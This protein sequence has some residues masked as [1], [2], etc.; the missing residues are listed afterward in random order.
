MTIK[1]I[2]LPIMFHEKDTPSAGF[3]YALDMAVNHHAHLTIG[4]G[5]SM[6]IIP[7]DYPTVSF[8]NVQSDEDERRVSLARQHAESL[9]QKATRAGVTASTDIFQDINPSIFEHFCDAAHVHDITV[10]CADSDEAEFQWGAMQAVL[11]FSGGAI[12]IVPS[13]WDKG[14]DIKHALIAWNNSVQASRA[15]RHAMPILKSSMAIEVLTVTEDEDNIREAAWQDIA[16]HLA[17]H[18]SNVTTNEI[19]ALDGRIGK[20]INNHAK[21]SR[22]DLV[23]MGGYGHSRLREWMM[24]GTTRDVLLATNVPLLLAH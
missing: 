12:I 14:A 21:L 22:T 1:R 19:P 17:A 13:K 16:T 9:R 2:Y 3:D 24:G 4:I 10:M 11:I 15:L 6:I 8:G 18:F 23:I 20:A 7:S 5:V